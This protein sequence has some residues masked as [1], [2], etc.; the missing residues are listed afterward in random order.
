M[1]KSHAYILIAIII[2]IV[3]PLFCGTEDNN[4]WQK[5]PV[6]ELLKKYTDEQNLSIILFDMDSD[7]SSHYKH[8][9]KVLIEKTDTVLQNTTDWIK[10]TPYFF[11]QHMNDMGM[12]IANKKN[13]KVTKQAVPAGYNNYVGNPKYGR[14]ETRS[15]GETFWSFYGKYAFMSSMFNMMTFRRSYWDDYNRGGYYGSSRGYYGPS[16]RSVFGTNSY[17]N[18][19]SGRSSTWARKP[20]TFKSKVRSKVSRSTSSG[21]SRFKRQRSSSRYRSSSSTRSRSGGY[22]K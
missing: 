8:K 22:G 21:S 3:L 13:G 9:Y 20:S 6:D 19:S 14:W 16:G 5:S 1:K 15:N 10:V 17:T 2:I 12:E 7:G 18:S 11:K 4:T